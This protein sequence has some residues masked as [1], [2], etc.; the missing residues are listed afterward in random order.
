MPYKFG[1]DS[2]QLA[3]G[4]VIDNNMLSQIDFQIV[5]IGTHGYG[6]M[7]T[8]SW[9]NRGF[10]VDA[11]CQQ[12][13]IATQNYGLPCGVYVFSYA[14]DA[15]SAQREAD[16]VCDVLDGWGLTT[17]LPIFID[18]ESAGV[19]SVGSYEMFQRLIGHQI[20]PSELQTIFEA[21][22]ARVSARGRTV[23]WYTNRWF[24]PN[25]TTPAWTAYMR[26]N[27]YFFWLASWTYASDPDTPCDVWQYAGDRQW[28]GITVDFNY[29]INDDVIDPTPA[30]PVPPDPPPTPPD[31]PSPTSNIPIW[32]ALKMS[33]G[34]DKNAKCALLL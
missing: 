18:W 11:Y 24:T 3:A 22:C 31:P 29:I 6:G 19:G 13:I 30:P 26:Q 1:I 2:Y 34:S 25:W 20:T 8:A 16:E 27:G 9:Y 5:R 33:K 14:W 10:S 17:R 32:L 21:F 23:G 12:N 7:G 28:N 4:Q 15:T